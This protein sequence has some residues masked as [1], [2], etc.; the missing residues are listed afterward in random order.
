MIGGSLPV[1]PEE[2]FALLR[3]KVEDRA[4][5]ISGVPPHV[6]VHA[7]TPWTKAVLL[8]LKEGLVDK[9]GGHATFTSPG[10][11]TEFMLDFVWWEV[12][13]RGPIMGVECEWTTAATESLAPEAADYD[14]RKLL[15]FKAP[16][17]VFVFDTTLKSSKAVWERLCNGL[18]K[19]QRHVKGERYLFVEVQRLQRPAGNPLL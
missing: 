4:K 17:K 12:S 3:D 14:F 2:I 19:F 11:T 13:G 9:H 7:S 8:T 1:E 16:L 18:K 10:A 6:P 5:E 15:C